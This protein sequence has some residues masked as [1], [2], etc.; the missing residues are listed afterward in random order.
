MELLGRHRMKNRHEEELCHRVQGESNR[1][2]EELRG[3]HLI[4]MP[5]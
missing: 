3:K 5:L 4:L 2:A 1:K